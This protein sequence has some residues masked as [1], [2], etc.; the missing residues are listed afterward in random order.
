MTESFQTQNRGTA[1]GGAYNIGR[2]GA[3]IAP[4][5]I[6]IIATQ[7]SIGLG[8][9]AMGGA[10]FL[11]GIIP[12]LFIPEKMYDPQQASFAAPVASARGA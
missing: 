6:G 2:F 10:Y 1:V 9:I 11:T 8:L 5:L 4:T 12:A 7:Y 3:A